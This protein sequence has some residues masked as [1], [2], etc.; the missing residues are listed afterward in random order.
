MMPPPIP[1]P[2]VRKIMV[3]GD[4]AAAKGELT[5]CRH[6][7]IVEQKHRACRSSWRGS[8]PPARL[9]IGRGDSAKTGSH[10]GPEHR[11][12]RALPRPRSAAVRRDATER[13]AT[14]PAIR[15][16]TPRGSFVGVGRRSGLRPESGRLRRREPPRS[17]CLRGPRLRIT[18]SLRPL[19]RNTGVFGGATAGGAA[20]ML[21]HIVGNVQELTG[22]VAFRLDAAPR[23]F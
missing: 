6:A 16:R 2:I 10:A 1:V 17:S 9:A 18:L 4:L 11:P 20:G 19:C 7:R 5:Q 8:G 3:P 13:S 12:V 14:S 23:R 15:G 21:Q 22:R